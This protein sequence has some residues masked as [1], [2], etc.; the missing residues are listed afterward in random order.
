MGSPLTTVNFGNLTFAFLSKNVI[1]GYQFDYL[2]SSSGAESAAG[3]FYNQGTIRCNSA[4]D[5]NNIFNF[6][7][8]VLQSF[9]LLNQGAC[10]ITATNIISPGNIVIGV[11]GQ[12]QMSGDNV[13]LSRGVFTSEGLLDI[14]QNP[15]GGGRVLNTVN[16]ASTG[17]VGVNTNDPWSPGFS[18]TPTTALASQSGFFGSDQ[19]HP[20]F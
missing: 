4:I 15:F 20:L 2:N 18:L 12:L 8:T 13:N 17:G 16:L 7:L 14:V 3:T 9:V 19:F 11:D 10:F 5:G 6:A 1:V